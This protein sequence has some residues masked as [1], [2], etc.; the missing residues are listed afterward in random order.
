MLEPLC[1]A[2]QRVTGVANMSMGKYGTHIINMSMD[3]YRIL[4]VT[5]VARSSARGKLVFV[6]CGRAI[7]QHHATY[8]HLIVEEHAHAS[9][10]A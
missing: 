2:L 7:Q 9:W 1:H 4:N 6:H 8:R 3:K 5:R 10:A